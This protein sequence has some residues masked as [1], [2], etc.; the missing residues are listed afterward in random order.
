MYTKA[1]LKGVASRQAWRRGG[2]EYVVGQVNK[3]NGDS[4][5]G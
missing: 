1:D 3:Y 4:D 5:S 2:R